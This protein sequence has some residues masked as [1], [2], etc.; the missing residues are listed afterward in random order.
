MLAPHALGYNRDERN[1]MMAVAIARV[2]LHEW[3]HIA[4]QSSHHSEHGLTKAH[5]GVADL[6]QQPAKPPV[7]RSKLLLD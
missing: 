3:M 7:K 2:I 5:F 6:L 4:T 1:R